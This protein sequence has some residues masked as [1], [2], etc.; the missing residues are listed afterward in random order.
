MRRRFNSGLVSDDVY[1]RFTI[2]FYLLGQGKQATGC[3]C[4][5]ESS[6]E[7]VVSSTLVFVFAS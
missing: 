4:V 6:G 2:V 7:G 1:W 5:V 3:H